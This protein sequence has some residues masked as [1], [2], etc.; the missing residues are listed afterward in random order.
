MN[1]DIGALKEQLEQ[2]RA[3]NRKISTQNIV[4]SAQIAE[5]NDELA[6]FNEFKNETQ[7][8]NELRKKTTDEE[9]ANDASQQNKLRIE[10]RRLILADI[11]KFTEENRLIKDKIKDQNVKLQKVKEENSHRITTIKA[12]KLIK[13]RQQREAPPAETTQVPEGP[14]ETK[15]EFS[16][17]PAPKVLPFSIENPKQKKSTLK[18]GSTIKRKKANRN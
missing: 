10:R 16:I 13:R 15:I 12:N 9:L 14:K 11:H 17:S 18:P 1:Q 7:M 8:Q 3:S 5:I 2:L 6:K 4:Y